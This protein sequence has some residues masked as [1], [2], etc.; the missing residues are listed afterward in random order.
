MI[1]VIVDSGSTKADWRLFDDESVIAITTPGLNP[2]FINSEEIASIIKEQVLSKISGFTPVAIYFYGAGCGAATRKQSV[3]DALM[4]CFTE[5]TVFVETDLL[6]AA[7]ALLKKEPGFAVILGTGTNSGY[8]D[9][10]NIIKSIDSLGY[11]LG[12][13]GSGAAI[14]K[15]LLRDYLRGYFPADLHHEFSLVCPMNR[16]MVLEQLYSKPFPNRFL[17]SWIPFAIEHQSQDIIQ[18]IV[19]ESF[20]EFFT[21]LLMHYEGIEKYPLCIAGSVGY[22]F[23]DILAETAK[24]YGVRIKISIQSPIDELLVYHRLY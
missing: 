1:K 23:R 5:A 19:R 12:D 4:K 9:G 16:E 20:E 21:G 18:K 14:G 24:D 10:A 15:K 2:Y 17:A 7:R 3:M 22:L 6:G 8:Y 13:E 11:F